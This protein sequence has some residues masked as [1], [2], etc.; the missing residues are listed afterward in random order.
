MKFTNILTPFLVLT[1]LVSLV[2]PAVA[3]QRTEAERQ[4]EL[5]D[6]QAARLVEQASRQLARD[7]EIDT[8]Y[9]EHYYTNVIPQIDA[10][11]LDIYASFLP[12]MNRID[13]VE[14]RMHNLI[15]NVMRSRGIALSPPAGATLPDG[16]VDFDVE[17]KF[18]NAQVC[19]DNFYHPNGNRNATEVVGNCALYAIP[20][21]GV[22]TDTAGLSQI[23]PP[24]LNL[25]GGPSWDS[26]FTEL[27][28]IPGSIWVSG[29]SVSPPTQLL[30]ALP[31]PFLPQGV[32]IRTNNDW[33][34]FDTQLVYGPDS[35][36]LMT[37]YGSQC[38][39][40]VPARYFPTTTTEIIPTQHSP[41]QKYNNSPL[42]TP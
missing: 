5:A 15:Y 4:Q 8:R 37:G 1:L 2:S 28:V 30:P 20:P 16:V 39:R 3:Q 18:Y 26:V 19:L 32:I 27:S 7:K 38:M 33:T 42:M 10:L 24:G 40:G 29:L 17:D 25:L 9:M 12:I 31:P 13:N 22:A 41:L 11:S 14:V 6:R 36:Q 23:R 35:V 34:E 21:S